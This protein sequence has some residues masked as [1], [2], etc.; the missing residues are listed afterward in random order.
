MLLRHLPHVSLR[1]LPPCEHLHR[2]AKT[3]GEFE[4]SEGSAE[5]GSGR[6]EEST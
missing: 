4:S 5:G 6:K 3:P 2:S 1:I